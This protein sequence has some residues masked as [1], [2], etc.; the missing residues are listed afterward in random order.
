MVR[1]GTPSSA[2]PLGPRRS[3]PCTA[4][5]IDREPGM[6]EQ[7]VRLVAAGLGISTALF[8][9]A[10]LVAPRRVARLF[11][12]RPPDPPPVSLLYSIRPRGLALGMGL[13]SAAG[14]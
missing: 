7:R 11:C 6:D 5:S 9:A 13:W 3:A 10:S 4:C 12:F 8:G 14:H 2:Q 1:G